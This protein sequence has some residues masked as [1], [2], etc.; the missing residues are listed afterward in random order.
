M[1]GEKFENLQFFQLTV[2]DFKITY[3]NNNIP[4]GS[5][6]PNGRNH[7]RKKGKEKKNGGK[8]K[9]K[10][11]KEDLKNVTKLAPTRRSLQRP[12]GRRNATIG[13]RLHSN[14]RTELQSGGIHFHSVAPK[15][16]QIPRPL[17]GYDPAKAPPPL[18]G[19]SFIRGSR[20]WGRGES[21]CGVSRQKNHAR[22]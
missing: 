16:S 7:R 19:G 3:G 15:G 22:G 1:A 5:T 10:K 6:T 17:P 2:K 12:F 20:L 21:L 14:P 8:E 11:T 4:I 9:E 13:I 18:G